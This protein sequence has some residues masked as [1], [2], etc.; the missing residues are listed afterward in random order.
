MTVTTYTRAPLPSELLHKI[1]TS[2]LADSIHAISVCPEVTQWDMGVAWTLAGT[3]FMW[4]EIVKG[5][6]TMAFAIGGDFG[7]EQRNYRSD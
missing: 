3:C 5:I 7:E 4:K 2:V 1:I 6:L